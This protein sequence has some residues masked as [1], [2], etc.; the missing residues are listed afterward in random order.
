MKL[1][2]LTILLAL[3]TFTACNS[4]NSSKKCT[5]NGIEVSCPL[6]IQESSAQ[7][8]PVG[9]VAPDEGTQT[10]LPRIVL[11]EASSRYIADGETLE[12]ID[13][14]QNNQF[15]LS[16]SGSQNCEAKIKGGSRFKYSVSR[17][18]LTLKN[19]ENG[20][21]IVFEEHYSHG[22]LF[23]STESEESELGI[24]RTTLEFNGTELIKRVQCVG[25]V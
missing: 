9:E 23:W 25:R 24:V 13:N 10:D 6:R 20:E 1:I 16:G 21:E 15:Y 4:K 11:V 19:V 8:S 12:L 7:K 3:F 2:S 14:D 5:F 17:K 22:V 18:L